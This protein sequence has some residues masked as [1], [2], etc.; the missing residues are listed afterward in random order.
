MASASLN[1]SPVTL[2]VAQI[3]L[4]GTNSAFTAQKPLPCRLQLRLTQPFLAYRHGMG[5]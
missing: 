2:L 3:D 5:A 1:T 4:T